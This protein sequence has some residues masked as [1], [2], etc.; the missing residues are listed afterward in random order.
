MIL[1]TD[2]PSCAGKSTIID[3]LKTQEVNGYRFVVVPS[4]TTRAPRP[5]EKNGIDYNFI[6]HSEFCGMIAGNEFVEYASIHGFMYG[7][8]KKT[9][10][11]L[12]E[13]KCIPVLDLDFAGVK[14]YINHFGRENVLVCFITAPE[15]TLR[16]RMVKRDGRIDNLRMTNGKLEVIS[17]NDNTSLF[18]LYADTST[19]SSECVAQRIMKAV[20]VR[21]QEIDNDSLS[22]DSE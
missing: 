3:L 20:S 1:I 14:N 8:A 13:D 11:D 6:S 18:D 21:L 19:E 16:K 17:F 5:N 2:G 9:F 12:I 15:Q 22:S 10:K 4:H 7:K